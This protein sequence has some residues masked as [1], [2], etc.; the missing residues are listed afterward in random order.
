MRVKHCASK[1][2]V[3]AKGKNANSTTDWVRSSI[4]KKEVKKAQEDGFLSSE[5]SIKFPSTNQIP[6]PPSG[7]R[8]MF[9]SFLLH[10]LSLHAHEFLR[11]HLF[12]Y[13]VQL[14]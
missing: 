9:L 7:Y 5:D 6:K 11:G 4:K 1:N 3:M 2:T 14:H 8:V 13:G 10:G 12:V